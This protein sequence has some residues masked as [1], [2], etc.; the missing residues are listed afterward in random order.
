MWWLWAPRCP[1]HGKAAPDLCQKAGAVRGEAK[2]EELDTG[3]GL[4]SLF[5]EA[6][7]S[8]GRTLSGSEC[9]LWQHL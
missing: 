3:L 9:Q 5:Q 1:S 4:G 8:N 2:G 7:E 6:S